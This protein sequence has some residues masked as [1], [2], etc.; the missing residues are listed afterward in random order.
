MTKKDQM[1]ASEAVYGL[2]AWL[3]TRDEA[4]TLSAKHDSAVAADLAAKFC[5]ANDLPDPREHWAGN[6][7]MGDLMT[8][9]ELLAGIVALS[10]KCLLAGAKPDATLAVLKD[11]I[12]DAGYGLVL[13]AQ[14][15]RTAEEAA[16]V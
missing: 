6:G 8:E 15:D 11:Y 16:N 3:T 7:M 4:V 13:K 12:S 5:E 2:L 10:D 9:D 14:A 1:T